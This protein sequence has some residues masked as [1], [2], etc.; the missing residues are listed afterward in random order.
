[1]NL[2]TREELKGKLDQNDNFKLVM[3]MGNW[4]FNAM[5]IPGSINV[6]TPEAATELLDPDDEIVVY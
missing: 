1:M 3:V 6:N 4:Q 2:I 5:H